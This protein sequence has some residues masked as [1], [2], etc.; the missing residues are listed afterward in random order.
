MTGSTMA[1]RAVANTTAQSILR[2]ERRANS[3][4]DV[5][6]HISAPN[7]TRPSIK[8]AAEP[9]RHD[10]T[11][12]ANIVQANASTAAESPARPR[13]RVPT[14]GPNFGPSGSHQEHQHTKSKQLIPPLP[15]TGRFSLS[16]IN[17]RLPNRAGHALRELPSAN[18]EHRQFR[19]RHDAA[20]EAR[21]G[22]RPRKPRTQE[23][24]QP[25]AS[26]SH[27]ARRL[28]ASFSGEGPFYSRPTIA[29]CSVNATPGAGKDGRADGA[30]GANEIQ[31]HASSIEE[32][33]GRY[34]VAAASNLRKFRFHDD[35]LDRANG[36]ARRRDQMESSPERK[37]RRSSPTSSHSSRINLK[38]KL[39]LPKSRTINVLSNITASLS[40]TSLVGS[41]AGSNRRAS[42][43]S[44]V[45]SRQSSSSSTFTTIYTRPPTPT[46]TEN[47]YIITAAQPSAYWSG[48]FLSLHDRFQA[49]ALQPDSLGSL[50]SDHAS[51][52]T[53]LPQQKAAYLNRGNLPL[54][55]T[56]AALD[57]YG[58]GAAAREPPR[59]V[60]ED[61]RRCRRVFHHLDSLCATDEA[62]KSLY[63]WQTGYARKHRRDALLPDS[64]GQDKGL[65]A[66]LFGRRVSGALA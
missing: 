13:R 43:G 59:A 58:G 16:R 28:S 15:S 63:A 60:S 47:P 56:T 27:G 22:Q 31:S 55:A 44:T 40:K 19:P 8:V 25:P 6:L 64:A 18:T 32:A 38:K 30:V 37:S 65:V 9:V 50:V 3:S 4:G 66:R 23:N 26:S 11:L 35:D 1:D 14:P 42:R 49:E 29:S 54:S 20:V 33:P 48:R 34:R 41:V 52:F 46:N 5:G 17:S 51:R 7:A 24:V 39:A 57:R 61:D 10:H 62:R 45:A 21:D 53:Q 36:G 2:G 12:A